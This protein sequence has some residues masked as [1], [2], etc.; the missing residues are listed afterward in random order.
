MARCIIFLALLAICTHTLSFHVRERQWQHHGH[1]REHQILSSSSG[2]PSST[3]ATQATSS[4]QPTSIVNGAA[5]TT[6]AVFSKAASTGSSVAVMLDGPSSSTVSAVSSSF[7]EVA[8]VEKTSASTDSSYLTNAHS[9]ITKLQTF[10]RPNGIWLAGWWNSANC[11][12]LLA[13]LRKYESSSFLT[14]ITD[15]SDGVFLTT[16]NKAP[17]NVTN[18]FLYDNYYDDEGWWT[19]ALIRTY[20]VTGDVSFLTAAEAT[21]NDIASGATSNVPCGGLRWTKPTGPDSVIAT[22]LFVQA[23]AELAMRYPSQKSYYLDL[24]LE[25]WNWITPHILVDNWIQADGLE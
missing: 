2:I 5:S 7:S 17:P 3:T 8:T 24:A 25:Q 22:L 16:L 10:Y 4:L 19:I 9:A 15:G 23:A 6:P 18:G 12:I 1:N 13:D 20:D 21:F 11:L 14:S